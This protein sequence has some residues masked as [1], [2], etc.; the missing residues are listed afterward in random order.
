MNIMALAF[1]SKKI[2]TGLKLVINASQRQSAS[3]LDM[4][5]YLIN[6]KKV[7]S[8]NNILQT[9]FSDINANLLTSEEKCSN[10]IRYYKTISPDEQEILLCNLARNYGIDTQNVVA[11]LNAA[12]SGQDR[13]QM[14]ILASS[15]RMR[16]ALKPKFKLLF[17]HIGKV[18]DGVKFLVDLRADVLKFRQKDQ[19]ELNGVLYQELN[20]AL[21]DL[22]LLWFTVGLLNLER[23][24][25]TASCDLVEKVSMYEAVHKVKNWE[26][27]KR[28][29]GP[30]RRCYIFT[31]SSMP[32]EPVVVLHTALTQE[33][34]SSIQGILRNVRLRYSS[35]ADDQT[36]GKGLEYFS[37]L[38]EKNVRQSDSDNMNFNSDTEDPELVKAA[39]FYSIT[40][41]QKGLQG[42][43]LGYYLIK[44]VVS[45]LKSEFPD[46]SQFSSLSPIP[47]FRDWLLL[48]LNRR[49]SE[50]GDPI[51]YPSEMEAL[52]RYKWLG[53]SPPLD[54]FKHL[55]VSHEW[56]RDKELMQVMKVP[57]MRLCA[58]YLYKQKRRNLALN[59]VANFHLGN[60]AVLWR[61]NFL[62]DTSLNGLNRSCTMMVNYR[63]YLENADA[64]S[65]NYL[66]NFQINA[67][68]DVLD[69]LK[70]PK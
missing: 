15:E 21:R 48:N 62:A 64:N 49:G 9:T 13:G 56:Y 66:E 10:F 34:S 27:I 32:R 54:K 65:R 39:I 11:V 4:L 7:H 18:K 19:T 6:G 58:Q 24:T 25:W 47:G 12:L 46:L 68:S 29:V 38:D 35:I 40:S 63:Y 17:S 67:S 8:G 43:D 31:H 37:G 45:K 16:Q 69:L 55:I 28:R 22:L 53:S 5:T 44:S 51:L 42:I 2:V 33:I 60:G 20:T 30:Y 61:I 52:A 3:Q 1:C 26:D 57:L 50:A 41:T 59:P 36:I 23:I 70:E 14:Q